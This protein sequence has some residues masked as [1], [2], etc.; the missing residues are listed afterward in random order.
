MSTLSRSIRST[1]SLHISSISLVPRNLL[2]HSPMTMSTISYMVC[3]SMGH[4]WTQSVRMSRPCLY[5]QN[6]EKQLKGVTQMLN[7]PNFSAG[8]AEIPSCEHDHSIIEAICLFYP[9]TGSSLRSCQLSVMGEKNTCAGVSR[10][11]TSIDILL[12]SPPG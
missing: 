4:L 7:F 1:N 11:T 9:K 3:L 12:V 8:P 6:V 2:A 10:R 5:N